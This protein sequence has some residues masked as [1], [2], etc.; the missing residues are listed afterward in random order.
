MPNPSAQTALSLAVL[1]ALL[2]A[3]NS[4][5]TIN[6]A[7][8]PLTPPPTEVTTVTAATYAALRAADPTA[9]TL[10][11]V[12]DAAAGATKC[13][14][15]IL[16]MAY[17]TVG[18]AGEMTNASGVVMIPQGTSPQCSG[19]RPTL[20]YA[21]GTASDSRYDLS[22]FLTEPTNPAAAEAMILLALY[23]SRGYAVIA[24][25]YAGYADST[26]GYH[27]YL[28][29]KQQ[30]S[31]MLH[32]LDHVRTH[33]SA[34]GAQFS[35]E[36][37]I[38]GLSQGGYVA[39]ATHKA[40]QAK[41]VNVWGSVP[42]SGPYATLDFVD[43]IMAGY[44]NGGATVFTPMY[45][46]A[47]DKAHDIYTHPSEVFAA[48]FSSQAETALPRVGGFELAVA[49]GLLPSTALFSGTPPTLNPP[50]QAFQQAG[51]GT[52]HLL[53]DSFRAAYLA[54]AQANR[55]T[56]QNKT[57]ALVKEA[58]LRDWTPKTPVMLC[59]SQNDPVVYFNNA[60]SMSAYWQGVPN[61][62]LL[63]LDSTP[64]SAPLNAFAPVAQQW[65]MALGNGGITPAAIHGQ[66]GVYC[67]LA[68]Y[69][70]FQKLRGL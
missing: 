4:N 57:R 43:S 17:N 29:E 69:G 67:G 51:F 55:Q 15:K 2:A 22:K 32:A 19:A 6:T 26:L 14:V 64:T 63:N 16:R 53:T 23:A 39:M 54:D 41:G 13:D 3:C 40:L 36:L 66:T 27:P 35:T 37:F 9:N 65:Q 44:V 70:L 48:P 12:A 50:L 34:M 68:A 45:L 59:G 25:N 20:L 21:H 30:T 31:E 11:T 10:F 7:T 52:P 8:L 61:T 47:L 58:D 24:P 60:T 33:S 42:I 49:S 5:K 1:A 38:T 56:P 46:R 28:D 18:S 62:Y